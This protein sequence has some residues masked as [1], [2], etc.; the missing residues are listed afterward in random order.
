MDIRIDRFVI[1][2]VLACLYVDFQNLFTSIIFYCF[3][4]FSIS[5]HFRFS[6]LKRV[7]VHFQMFPFEADRRQNVL[8]IY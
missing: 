5:G 8:L 7:T 6:G 4:V 1:Q 2:H 3:Q